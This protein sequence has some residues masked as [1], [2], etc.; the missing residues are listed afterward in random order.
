MN[1]D[2]LGDDINPQDELLGRFNLGKGLKK[3]AKKARWFNPYTAAASVAYNKLHHKKAFAGDLSAFNR[4]E[5]LGA[6]GFPINFKIDPSLKAALARTTEGQAILTHLGDDELGKFLPGLMKVVKKVG[7]VTRGI[8]TAIA[9]T[10][11]PSSM[12]DALAKIDPTT[13]T[14]LLDKIADTAGTVK[15][16]IKSAASTVAQD[17]AAVAKKEA[18]V[19]QKNPATSI[20]IAAAVAVAGVLFLTMRKK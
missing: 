7:T 16:A 11:L 15:T 3:I 18:A 13:H 4:A 10:V 12:V 17:T 19:V 8:T 6:D 2:V 9:K 1:V 14:K 5:L 20:M